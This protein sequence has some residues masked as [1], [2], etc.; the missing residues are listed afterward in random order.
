MGINGV[1]NL[2]NRTPKRYP[3]NTSSS[4]IEVAKETNKESP[5]KL[6]PRLAPKL[7]P[8]YFAIF[9]INPRKANPTP[10]ASERYKEGKRFFK[11]IPKSEA[12]ILSLGI[13]YKN[14][15]ID[16]SDWIWPESIIESHDG[17]ILIADQ[18]D[19]IFYFDENDSNF[20]IDKG[21][22]QNRRLF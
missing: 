13:I 16:Q 22:K 10:R 7:I 1:I 3:L 19:G 9:A 15:S 2:F 4:V 12:F 5:K 6:V 17:K 20:V 21:Q 8:L 11:P 14:G 18:K